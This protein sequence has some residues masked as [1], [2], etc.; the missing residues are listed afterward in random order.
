MEKTDWIFLLIIAFCLLTIGYD[1]GKRVGQLDIVKE[2]G[3]DTTYNTI[4]LDSLQYNI[5]IKDTIIY[6]IKEDMEDEV[7]K[8]L[9]A[10]D[11]TAVQQ[12]I[13]LASSK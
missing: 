8:A 9:N 11:S 6:R 12:F 4:I 13:E 5:I 7:E 2:I 1:I 10:D 3:Y